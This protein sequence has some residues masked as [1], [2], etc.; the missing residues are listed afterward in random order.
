M[1]TVVYTGTENTTTYWSLVSWEGDEYLLAYDEGDCQHEE[2]E[3]YECASDVWLRC[4]PCGGWAPG[5]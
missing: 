2:L 1:R 5:K 3:C 4:L